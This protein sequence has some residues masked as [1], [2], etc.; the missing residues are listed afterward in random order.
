METITVK[1][2]KPSFIGFAAFMIVLFTMPLGHAAMIIMGKNAGRELSHSR[3]IPF[4]TGRRRTRRL[5]LLYEK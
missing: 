2:K 4:G 1:T 5:G 3:S